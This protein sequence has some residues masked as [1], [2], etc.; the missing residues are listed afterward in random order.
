M[1]GEPNFDMRQ[2]STGYMLPFF[3][4]IETQRSYFTWNISC[5][6]NTRNT[7][8]KQTNSKKETKKER[9]RE[10]KKECIK[11]MAQKTKKAHTYI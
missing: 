3:D 5:M 11:T 4:L 8:T 1:P 2:F 6:C 9:K 7:N 10:K